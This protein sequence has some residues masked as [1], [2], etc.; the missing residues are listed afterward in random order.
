M[1]DA[2]YAVDAQATKIFV[3]TKELDERAIDILR[4]IYLPEEL[5]RQVDSWFQTLA[6]GSD[7][8][9]SGA[10]GNDVQRLSHQ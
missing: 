7:T 8:L 5:D 1:V 9:V 4:S 2:L 10:L 3:E 6:Q